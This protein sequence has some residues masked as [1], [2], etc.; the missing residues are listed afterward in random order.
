M[1]ID[2]R[3]NKYPI[4]MN[5]R[6]STLGSFELPTRVEGCVPRLWA[7]KCQTQALKQ[8]SDFLLINFFIRVM[9]KL[10]PNRFAYRCTRA[11]L[12]EAS[13]VVST[14]GCGDSSLATVSIANQSV[15]NL[16]Y[17]TPTVANV[18]ISFSIITYGDEVRLAILA[19]SG[20]IANPE[21]MTKQFIRQVIIR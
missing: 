17:F 1:P 13:C 3:S 11:V 18:A 10:F 16:I 21:Y 5:A 14:L 7:T 4:K 8:S 15:K 2:L 12:N 19:D 6:S 9:F 20:V